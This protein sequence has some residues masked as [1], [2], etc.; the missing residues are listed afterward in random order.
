MAEMTYNCHFFYT[1]AIKRK[2]PLII[3]KAVQKFF[4]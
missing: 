4:C 3:I 2:C 1:R